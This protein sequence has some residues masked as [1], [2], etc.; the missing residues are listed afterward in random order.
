MDHA[1]LYINEIEASARYGYSRSWFQR[2]RWAGDG[3]LFKKFRGKV[4]YPL[5]ETDQWFS[6]KGLIQSTSEFNK[7]ER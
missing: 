2:C 6:D 4:L 3:P 7:E 5:K 1:Q